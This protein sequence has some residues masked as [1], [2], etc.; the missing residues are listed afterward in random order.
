MNFEQDPIEYIKDMLENKSTAK[1]TTYK[2]ILSAYAVL[3]QESQ[4]MVNE[5]S[6]R[7][8]PG[9]KD[10]TVA[11]TEESEREFQVK[12][13]GDLVIFVLGTNI[14]TF[15]DNHAIMN[16]GYIKEKEV[17]RYFGQIM[18]YDFMSDSLKYNRTNDPGYLLA[19][20]LINHEN[21]YF[22]EGEKQLATCNKISLKPITEGDLKDLVKTA[23]VM[24]IENDLMALPYQ[25]V[26]SIT[27]S[28]KLDH[29]PEFCGTKKI[30]FR[31]SYE[32]KT[33]A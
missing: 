2:N 30:G 17:N 26:K 6:R 33:E 15:E 28:Q 12:L 11:F 31:M 1:Q 8:H 27:L 4:N 9:D 18:I 24:A 29:T 19:R 20:L 5:L 13:A 7:A 23:L 10:V 3:A 32:H 22:I 21:R 16:E 25:Q 14:V